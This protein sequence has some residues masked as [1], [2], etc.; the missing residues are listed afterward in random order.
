M[1]KRKM[2]RFIESRWQNWL[3]FCIHSQV[4]MKENFRFVAYIMVIMDNVDRKVLN[5]DFNRKER[6]EQKI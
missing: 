5:R 2:E 1:G 4:S 6:R 3:L